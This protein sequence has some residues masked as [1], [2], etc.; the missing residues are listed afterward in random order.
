[1]GPA[2][3]GSLRGM[4]DNS[5]DSGFLQPTFGFQCQRIHEGVGNIDLFIVQHVDFGSVLFFISGE[6]NPNTIRVK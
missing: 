4:F 5:E 1:M 3:D 6:E 2:T